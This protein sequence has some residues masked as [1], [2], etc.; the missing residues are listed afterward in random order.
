MKIL[1]IQSSPRSGSSDSIGL[2]SFF[3]QECQASDAVSSIDTLNVWNETLPEF[4]AKT[5]EAKYKA[6]KHEALSD[7]ER[8]LWNQIQSLISRFQSA[9]RILLGV[10]MWN[11]S[12]P[13]KLKQLIDLVMQ[14][15]YLFSYDGREYSPCL[16]IAKGIVVYTRGSE[17]REGTPIPPSLF[18]HQRPYIDFWLK[19]IGV[20]E[21]RSV[22][23]D[24]A[25]NRDKQQSETALAG[26]RAELKELAAWFLKTDFKA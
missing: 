8:L 2:T 4:A 16:N 9:D 21:V 20:R 5:I 7:E 17:Y 1:D 19:L 6:V 25:W 18:D 10:P 24:N 15:N 13:Y 22:V 26:G 14:R 3:I 11:F 12:I 23:V